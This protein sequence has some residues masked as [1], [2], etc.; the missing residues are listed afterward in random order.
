MH[1][2]FLLC[3]IT[4][5]NNFSS[6]ASEVAST[7]IFPL[8]PLTTSTKT[9]TMAAAGNL[10]SKTPP[11]SIGKRKLKSSDSISPNNPTTTTVSPS[12]IQNPKYNLRFVP[13]D[14]IKHAPSILTA[15]LQSAAMASQD[16]SLEFC[17]R[18]RT[19]PYAKMIH[20]RMLL[21]A[22]DFNL[23]HVDMQAVFLLAE[24]TIVMLKNIV[25][26]TGGQV[27]DEKEAGR[28]KLVR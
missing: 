3:I 8:M 28:T 14:P 24:A 5:C 25:H 10:S 15:S 23:A 16:F 12:S 1:N 26:Q 13:V 6:T 21:A 18:E 19:L 11:P 20:S 22:L 7:T 2:E 17:A 27:R 9:T 4:K